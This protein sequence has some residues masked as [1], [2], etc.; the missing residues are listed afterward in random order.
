MVLAH[1]CGIRIGGCVSR[2]GNLDQASVAAEQFLEDA[3]TTADPALRAPAWD[4][5]ARVAA[6]ERRL[7]REL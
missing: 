6:A 4:A 7:A 2:L 5:M 3:L 1:D